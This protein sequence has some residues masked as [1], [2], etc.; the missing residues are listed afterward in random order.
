M[1]Q[2]LSNIMSFKTFLQPY[3]LIKQLTGD[4]T[5]N[6]KPEEIETDKNNTN[7]GLFCFVILLN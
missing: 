1:E 3:N 2:I 7:T 5:E 6:K 4:D